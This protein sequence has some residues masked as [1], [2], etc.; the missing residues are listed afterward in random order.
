M[1][2]RL[3]LTLAQA[4]PDDNPAS[5][6]SKP[7][8]QFSDFCDSVRQVQSGA[9]TDHTFLYGFLIIL[10]VAVCIALLAR[11]WESWHLGEIFNPMVEALGGLLGGVFALC[12]RGNSLKPARLF[13]H[14]DNVA[15]PVPQRISVMCPNL[16]CRAILVVPEEARGANVQCGVCKHLVKIPLHARAAFHQ[17]V[18][19][20]PAPRHRVSSYRRFLPLSSRAPGPDVVAAPHGVHARF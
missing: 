3:C 12:P 10:G 17:A 15:P 9:V 4:S 16:K 1:L 20:T 2:I 7:A 13:G 14:E 5:P 19:H 18:P 6:P 11:A 8:L